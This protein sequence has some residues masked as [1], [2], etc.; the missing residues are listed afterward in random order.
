MRP[1]REGG[2]GKDTLWLRRYLY[3]AFG[4][5]VA[6]D[7]ALMAVIE[8]ASG[9]GWEKSL[10]ARL[11][12]TAAVAGGAHWA[13]KEL[14]KA[15]LKALGITSKYARMV[16]DS[17][18]FGAA[19]AA[20]S[21]F[22]YYPFIG[23]TKEEVASATIATTAAYVLGGWYIGRSMD[24]AEQID[25]YEETIKE[26][27]GPG[28]QV[29]EW[30]DDL[31]PRKQLVIN[32]VGSL[33][34]MAATYTTQGTLRGP[35]LEQRVEHHHQAP[36]APSRTYAYP[37]WDYGSLPQQAEGVAPVIVQESRDEPEDAQGL[38]SPR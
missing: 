37:G 33:A 34:V 6:V 29:K 27:A 25:D 18:L 20:V 15:S 12:A 17:A 36:T 10:E 8:T 11:W 4:S 5:Q 28:S 7:N 38:D 13:A 19:N 35:D 32:M 24:R 22:L 14:R 26:Y 31:T 1:V 16:H 21:Y 3:S 23:C 2:M 30:Y 9:M